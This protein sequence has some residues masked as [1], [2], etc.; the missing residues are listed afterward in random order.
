MCVEGKWR[1]ATI[2]KISRNGGYRCWRLVSSLSCARS[3]IFVSC[4]SSVRRF[5]FLPSLNF[6]TTLNYI[7]QQHRSGQDVFFLSFVF[8]FFPFVFFFLDGD[9][10]WKSP[11]RTTCQTF[12]PSR[13]FSR[14]RVADI[15]QGNVLPDRLSSSFFW[16]GEFEK[17]KRIY[18]FFNFLWGWNNTSR[19]KTSSPSSFPSF[20]PSEMD[21]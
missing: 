7:G 17:M 6:L 5:F 1:L 10:R 4:S 12:C 14:R 19:P 15:T 20:W 9:A 18:I 16:V 11:R 2:R 21:F 13:R 3:Y 8:T